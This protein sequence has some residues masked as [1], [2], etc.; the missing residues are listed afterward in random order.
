[1]Y[2]FLSVRSVLKEQNEAE[3]ELE[4]YTLDDEEI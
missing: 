2:S 3:M 4:R 1:M